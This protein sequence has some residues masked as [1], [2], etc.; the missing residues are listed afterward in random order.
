VNQK[1]RVQMGEVKVSADGSLES[2]L[3]TCVSVCLY[4]G[5]LR[6]GGMT[7]ISRARCT[8]T[9]PSGKYIK[10]GG[11]HYADLAIPRLIKLLQK[12]DECLD[13]R[14]LKLFVFGGLRNE[15]PVAETIA[16]LGLKMTPSGELRTHYGSKYGFKLAGY[17]INQ[18][19]NRGVL[20]DVVNRE[21]I[22][23]QSQLRGKDTP[24][25][26]ASDKAAKRFGF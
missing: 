15:G 7:H 12:H 13:L 24:M 19:L 22:V 6:L 1:L 20:F 21:V 16:E 2:Q 14:S 17:D 10:Q 3:G 9:T 5:K 26:S 4:H 25:P 11:F 8:D 23:S 18:E